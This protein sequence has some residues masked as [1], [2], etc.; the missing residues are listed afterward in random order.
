MNGEYVYPLNEVR[1]GDEVS[2]RNGENSK[3]VLS[4]TVSEIVAEIPQS[5]KLEGIPFRLDMA[6]PDE[7]GWQIIALSRS[8]S[9]PVEPGLYLD[10]TGHVSQLHA[11]GTWSPPL[12]RGSE[13]EEPAPGTAFVRVAPVAEIAAQ[14]LDAV[15]RDLPNSEASLRSSVSKVG[16]QFGVEPTVWASPD[17]DKSD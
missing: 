13:F 8:S 1:L 12:G 6:T 5:I 11:D 10:S 7:D 4:G 14:V 15:A 3:T 17:S 16:E 9:L 2:V